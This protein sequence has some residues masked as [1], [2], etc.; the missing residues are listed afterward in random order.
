MV[1]EIGL[2]FAVE[3]ESPDLKMGIILA[4]FKAFWKNT[5]SDNESLKSIGKYHKL[6]GLKFY[7]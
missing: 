2:E 5:N 7:I 3:Y 4:V 1:T 6:E